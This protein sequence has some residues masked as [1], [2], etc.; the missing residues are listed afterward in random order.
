MGPV[1]RRVAVADGS[2]QVDEQPVVDDD[3]D[4]LDELEPAEPVDPDLLQ[5]STPQWRR[6]TAVEMLVSGLIGLYASF[7]LSIEAWTLEG[8]PA[9]VFSCD[10]NSVLSCGAVARTWQATLLGFPNAFLGILFESV[11]LTIS[12]ATVGGVVFPRWFMRGAQAL[13]TVALAFALWL[14]TQSYFVIHALCPWCLLITATTTLVWAGLTRINVRDG[15]LPLGPGARRFVV[16]GSDWFVT[17]A[18]LIVL[19]ALIV[20][21]YG[22]RLIA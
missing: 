2:A 5:P 1:R 8:D 12:V 13:Y 3:L 20:L 18:F 7:V 6:G 16:S 4:D 14:F 22:A 21:R 15:H 17:V 11:V 19:G 9:A 10:V